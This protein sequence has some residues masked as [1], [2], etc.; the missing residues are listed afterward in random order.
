MHFL[1]F[2]DKETYFQKC[3]EAGMTTINH[4]TNEEFVVTNE[5]LYSIDEIG[6]IYEGG[7]VSG[8]HANYIGELPECF[9]KYVIERP[10]TP[11]R[12]FAGL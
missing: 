12:V 9:E 2:P 11:H 8:W 7:E 5:H 6:V 4:D 3:Q 1:K 10:N